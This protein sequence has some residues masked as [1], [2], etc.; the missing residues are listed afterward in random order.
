MCFIAACSYLPSHQELSRTQEVLATVDT[1][2]EV[3]VSCDGGLL[4]GD[5]LC[6]DVAMKDGTRLRFERVGFN[7][8]GPTAANV[9]VAQV[10]GLVP[11]VAMCDGTGPPNFHRESALGHRFQPTLLDVKDAVFRHRDVLEEVEFWPQCP[12]FW[13]GQDK[14]GAAYTFCARKSGA[15]E[16]PPRPE[17]CR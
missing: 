4:A 11:R 5:R 9:V 7:A 10:A 17:A 12:Q 8:F 13:E 3:K 15:T 16:E 2:A 14:Q 6:V 1:V